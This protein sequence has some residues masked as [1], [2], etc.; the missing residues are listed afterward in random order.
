M[1][2]FRTRVT[3]ALVGLVVLGGAVPAEADEVPATLQV[4]ILVKVLVYD[5]T[6]ATRARD[7]LRLAVI[8]DPASDSSRRSRDEFVKAFNETPRTIAGKQIE[9]LE[10]AEEKLEASAPNIDIVYVS[11]GSDIGK[12]VALAKKHHMITFASSRDAVEA[13][14]VLGLV[15]RGDKPKLLINVGASVASGM[16][17]DPQVL[18]LAELVRGSGS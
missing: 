2:R 12:V 4:A 6:L 11:G 14:V 9:L 13:G 1:G 5:R 7:G 15:P 3:A 8:F 18:R 16:E 17:L 10:L